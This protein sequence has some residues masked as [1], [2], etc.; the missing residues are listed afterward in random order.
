MD[1]FFKSLRKNLL[2]TEEQILNNLTNCFNENCLWLQLAANK[3]PKFACSDL[4]R[5]KAVIIDGIFKVTENQII[6]FVI[7]KDQDN[8]NC[9][10][11]YY[12]PNDFSGKLISLINIDNN[13]K[14]S[15][16]YKK[17]QRLEINY[18]I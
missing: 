12:S 2:D 8:I 4:Q 9:T 17:G 11:I 1:E 14:M 7:D 16:S 15:Y 5:V 18:S 3:D 10:L 6:T 13:E